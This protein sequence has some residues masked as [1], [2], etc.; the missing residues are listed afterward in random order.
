M[1]KIISEKYQSFKTFQKEG[2]KIPRSGMTF[3]NCP[4][5]GRGFFGN[6]CPHCGEKGEVKRFSMKEMAITSF[7]S[8]A[9]LDNAL[10]RTAVELFTR[11]GYLI[12]RYIHGH[13]KMYVPPVKIFLISFLLLGILKF[14][15]PHAADA[16]QE[17][18]FFDWANFAKML[19]AFIGEN[20]MHYVVAMSTWLDSQP[21]AEQIYYLPFQMAALMLVFRK[22]RFRLSENTPNWAEAFVLLIYSDALETM[23]AIALY[24]FGLDDETDILWFVY[25]V[26]ILHQMF[27]IGWLKALW[28]TALVALLM[29]V[30][31]MVLVM[32]V[33]LAMII[34]NHAF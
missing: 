16:I 3:H 4:A 19:T 9:R 7:V 15:L 22:T 27:R 12:S 8:V 6:F 25:M 1:K 11:P 24:P 30:F 32:A 18:D 34:F 14:A 23:A 20:V 26:V 33:A 29:T 10:L 28:R 2:R 31:L 5:C 17:S 21:W 13:R